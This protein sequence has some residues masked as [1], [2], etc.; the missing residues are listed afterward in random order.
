MFFFYGPTDS[1]K[2]T[3]IDAISSTLGNYHMSAAFTTWCVQTTSGG[4]RGDLV[5]LA[6]ARLVTSVEIRKGAKFDEELIK[7][8][9]GGDEITAAAKYEAEVSFRATFTMILAAN[10]SP[11][12]RDDDEGMW[13][14]MRRVPFVHVP[15]KKDPKVKAQLG[16]PNVSGP[17]ILAWAVRGCLDWQKNGLGTSKA[18]DDCTTEYRHDMDRAALFF[19]AW[20][21]FDE[22]LRVAR[23]VLRQ[24]YEQWCKENNIKYPLSSKELASRLYE[25][26]VEPAKSNGNNIWKGVCVL[27]DERLCRGR[28]AVEGHGSPKIPLRDLQ[29]DFLESTP[30]SY[31]VTPRHISEE[32]NQHGVD[33]KTI[34]GSD[35]LEPCRIGDLVAPPHE[36]TSEYLDRLLP[37]EEL[38]GVRFPE[39]EDE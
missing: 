23:S 3:F 13:N 5:R 7:R 6:G 12:V 14:R 1:T 31:T 35:S 38:Y 28:V 29:N 32:K 39:N 36:S 16:D 11:K 34:G 17:A 20:C 2:S 25:H 8:V 9:V 26:G 4:N 27:V 19:D 30:L 18:I 15:P 10:D 33:S 21:E 22:G 37:A 24:K